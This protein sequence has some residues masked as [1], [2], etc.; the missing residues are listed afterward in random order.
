VKDYVGKPVIIAILSGLYVT[1][2]YVTNN[3]SMLPWSSVLFLAT[4]LILPLMLIVG[5]I[6]IRQWSISLSLFIC[7]FFIL[8]CLRLPIFE[9]QWVA[10]WI[11]EL[12]A[13]N[14]VA[15]KSIYCIL[16]SFLVA[17]AFRNK[18]HNFSIL[19]VVVT[20]SA[21]LTSG[22]SAYR[23][24]QYNINQFGA[25]TR[26]ILQEVELYTKPNIYFILADGYSSF[27][28]M[29]QHNIDQSVFLSYL[30][31][32]NFRIYPDMFSNYHPT[33]ASMPAMLNMEHHYYDFVLSNNITEVSSSGRAVSGG[34]NNLVG[35][36]REQGY[37]IKYIHQG[38]YLLLQGCT[39]DFCYPN[40]PFAGG[41]MIASRLLLPNPVRSLLLKY[42]WHKE[43]FE[44]VYKQVVS[45]IGQKGN[46]PQFQY[47]HLYQPGH[48][49]TLGQCKM[50]VELR[51]YAQRVADTN[52]NLIKLIDKIVS[53]DEEAVIVL[54]A[55]HGPFITNQCAYEADINTI[56]EYQDRLGVLAAIR[57]PQNYQGEFDNSMHT[58]INLFRYVIASFASVDSASLLSLASEESYVMGDSAILKIIE[59]GLPLM[60][61]VVFKKEHTETAR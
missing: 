55:D 25:K 48:A 40:I 38:L 20:I 37:Q 57:W 41:K 21:L 10:E 59:D 31:G 6:Q 34:N 54:A 2:F 47:I 43:T 22:V 60:P 42:S 30:E 3:L 14:R 17:L 58:T 16:P 23:N 8:L 52:D 28:Y 51:D 26:S 49:A 5:V 19:L 33:T 9:I 13:N 18:P 44:S 24:E 35:F 61:P 32:N 46:Q 27:A 56:S 50:D 39:A 15:L 1:V 53:E 12:N 45:H 11:E 36:L 4:V 7:M 29:Q